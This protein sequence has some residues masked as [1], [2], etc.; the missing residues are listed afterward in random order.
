MCNT[1]H[2]KILFEQIL[3]YKGY[4]RGE[5]TCSVELRCAP[6]EALMAAIPDP[7][8]SVRSHIRSLGEVRIVV[9]ETLRECV[10]H[11]GT[12]MICSIGR[13]R[14]NVVVTRTRVALVCH[15]K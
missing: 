7:H 9:R 13:I 10:F 11:E 1:L 12:S 2:Q 14:M 5:R 8:V 3:W 15:A 4:K 6:R